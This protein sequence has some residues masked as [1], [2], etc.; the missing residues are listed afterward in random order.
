[1]CVRE[2]ERD[3]RCSIGIDG[4][5]HVELLTSPLAED[6]A[7][8]DFAR[9]CVTKCC[10]NTALCDYV[11]IYQMKCISIRCKDLESCKPK[12]NPGLNSTMIKILKGW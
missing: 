8:A 6:L 3:H 1:M 7:L 12:E 4:G 9:L 5:Y 11:W 2:K 10:D